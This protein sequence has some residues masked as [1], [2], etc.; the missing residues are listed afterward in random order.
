MFNA[1]QYPWD[2]WKLF[3]ELADDCAMTGNPSLQ[4]VENRRKECH[5]FCLRLRHTVILISN[6]RISALKKII[7]MASIRTL[8]VSTIVFERKKEELYDFRQTV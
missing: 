8:T 2:D 1:L 7:R 6:D 4:P 3:P 5:R